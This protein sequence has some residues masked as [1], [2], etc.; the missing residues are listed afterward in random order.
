MK[1]TFSKVFDKNEIPLDETYEKSKIVLDKKRGIVR[2][3]FRPPHFND[4]PKYFYYVARA[5]KTRD[6]AAFFGLGCS[7]DDKI[8]QTKA[9]T[10]TMERYCMLTSDP[11]KYV[12]DV[13]GNFDNA[14]DPNSIVSFSKNQLKENKF[15]RFRFYKEFPFKWVEGVSLLTKKQTWVPAQLT[16][17][18]RSP[19]NEFA[20]E[21]TI[22]IAITNGASSGTSM[23]G[24]T[25][26]GI[27]E[28]VERDAFMITYLNRLPRSRINVDDE[29]LKEIL[30]L[31]SRYKL[32]VHLFDLTLDIPI[33]TI[34]AVMIDKSGFGPI[35]CVGA[36][37]DLN[38]KDALLGSLAEAISFRLHTRRILMVEDM[39]PPRKD[40]LITHRDRVLYWNKP[41]MMKNLDFL[42]KSKDDENFSE[43]KK[44]KSGS[45][46]SLKMTT[47]ILKKGKIETV[48]VDITRP[49][50][51]KFGFKVSMTIMPELQP[52][53]LDENYPYYGG[54][55][56][57]E[58]PRIL[59][60]E[61]TP[62]NERQLNKVP[63]PF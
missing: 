52:F 38:P 31:F 39:K 36:K 53:Y 41:G 27:W 6:H 1:L 55:R 21:P 50:I 34:L 5:P 25:A 63:H 45:I 17:L 51:E 28:C 8:A 3:F 43:I 24:A 13:F 19:V 10:E 44:R 59:G 9:F 37:A 15:A 29:E 23:S 58:V 14:I 11:K 33:P 42:L 46:K 12:T 56:I 2:N 18:K 32:D 16:T 40:E 49:L 48:V 30:N 20:K 57:F 35:I 4:E 54:K 62:K 26:R 60:Y 61:N 22:R 7:L 47:E